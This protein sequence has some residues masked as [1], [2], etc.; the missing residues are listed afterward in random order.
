MMIE[1]IAKTV[2]YRDHNA[3]RIYFEAFPKKERMPYPLMI[4]MSMLWNTDFLIF[5]D[6]KK[7]VGIIYLAKNH[8][9]IFVMFFAVAKELRGRGY[10]SAILRYI[11]E[12]YKRKTIISIEPCY[13]NAVDID[14]RQKRKSFY[15]MNGYHETGYM[16]KLNGIEQE[17]I[18]FGG[19]FTKREFM[20]FFALYSNCTVW[21]KIWKTK[22]QQTMK[23]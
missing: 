21:P 14:V 12:R 13:E 19:Y 9:L 2:N 5:Y 7:P 6:G 23:N 22:S 17:I 15:S 8:R 1:L 20:T 16:M 18:I 3:K 11:K 10:G 4:A